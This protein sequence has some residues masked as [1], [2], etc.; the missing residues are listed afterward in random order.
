MQS[1]TIIYQHLW[2]RVN[3]LPIMPIKG[4][5]IK[6]VKI[7][8]TTFKTPPCME[9]IQHMRHVPLSGNFSSKVLPINNV[10]MFRPALKHSN[11]HR[12]Y[13]IKTPVKAAT[14]FNFE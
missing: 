9:I 10:S 8:V 12:I 14:I 13:T 6:N 11:G 3:Q 7:P 5:S 2:S 4:D 1:Q